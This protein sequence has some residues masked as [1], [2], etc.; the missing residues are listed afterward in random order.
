M[1]L[2]LFLQCLCVTVLPL[3]LSKFSSNTVLK[4][5]PIINVFSSFSFIY[6]SVSKLLVSSLFGSYT[7]IMVNS[8]SFITSSRACD[9]PLTTSW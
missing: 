3:R 4:S 9:L 5:P 6:F 8:V 1:F 7:F 2:L